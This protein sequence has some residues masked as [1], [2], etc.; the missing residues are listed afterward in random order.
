[1][2]SIDIDMNLLSILNPNLVCAIGVCRGF[3]IAFHAITLRKQL[4]AMS[5]AAMAWM[6]YRSQALVESNLFLVEKGPQMAK[7]N[8]TGARY[9]LRKILT[10]N[11]KGDITVH[12]KPV[13]LTRKESLFR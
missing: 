5:Q 13:R 12:E 7:V 4:V 10:T 6:Y 2:Q 9:V 1:M 11:A 8:K 3:S